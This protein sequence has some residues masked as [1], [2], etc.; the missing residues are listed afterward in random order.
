MALA[1]AMQHCLDVKDRKY[2]LR[3]YPKCFV[4]SDAVTNLVRS[5]L[6][7]SREDAVHMGRTLA[8]V[9]GLFSHVTGDHGKCNDC[10]AEGTFF[11]ISIDSTI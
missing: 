4:G 2:R 11:L 7:A 3:S 1:R 8:N 10:S 9:M 6:A 5:G